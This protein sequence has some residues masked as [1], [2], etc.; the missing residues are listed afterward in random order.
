MTISTRLRFSILHRDDFR[1]RYCG[2]GSNQIDLHVDHVHPKS[3]GGSDDPSNLVTACKECNLG[4]G[5]TILRPRA[6]RSLPDSDGPFG[7][8]AIEFVDGEPRFQGRVEA[9]TENGLGLTVRLADWFHGEYNEIRLMLLDDV[10]L[11]NTQ[12][13]LNSFMAGYD[14]CEDYYEEDVA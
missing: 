9:V 12:E 11:F 3:K 1:C 2:R 8:F 5:V 13:E 10:R 7:K 6:Q 4:K 14:S